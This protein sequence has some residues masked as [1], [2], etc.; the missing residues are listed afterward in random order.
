MEI[1]WLGCA[2]FLIKFG[3]QVIL[4]DPY[5]S[6]NPAARPV[7][8][9]GPRE[10]GAASRIFISH[11]HFDH[12]LDVPAIAFQ[13]K[14]KVY[15]SRGAAAFLFK[16]GLKK[17]QV[18]TICADKWEGSWKDLYVRAFFSKHVRF[19]KRLLLSTLWKMKVRIFRYLPLFYRYPC[20]QVLSWQ[21]LI[22]GKR[23]HFFGSAGASMEELNGL[24]DAPID[25]L[26]IPLQGHSNICDI[27]ARYVKVL[28]PKLV[29]PHHQ[30]DFFS[31]HFLFGG[32]HAICE[33]GQT[34]IAEHPGK[35]LET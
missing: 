15:C 29:I 9:L 25:I 4:L 35:N 8:L 12:I 2:G 10:M 5:L 16:A 30:D 22:K 18:V 13:T 32:Y 28:Q 3:D 26:L 7:Q 21:F 1:Q 20:G 33:P 24:K 23:I 31:S 17:D 11:G 14:A 27:A 34:R 19:D 6:R